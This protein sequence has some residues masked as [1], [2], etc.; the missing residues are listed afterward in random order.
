MESSETSLQIAEKE[1]THVSVLLAQVAGAVERMQ[2]ESDNENYEE[3]AKL[4]KEIAV[5]AQDLRDRIPHIQA[6]AQKFQ[7]AGNVERAQ[8]LMRQ[9][10]DIEDRLKELEV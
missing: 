5:I 3:A 6:A 8:S 10:E 1:P 9:A 4:K 7:M 2:E